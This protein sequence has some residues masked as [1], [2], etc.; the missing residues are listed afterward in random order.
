M[1]IGHIEVST[2][3][4]DTIRNCRDFLATENLAAYQ[5]SAYI[6]ILLLDYLIQIYRC[7]YEYASIKIKVKRMGQE[8]II[9]T[10][11]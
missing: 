7:I 1:H 2:I 11:R 5:L 10:L 8:V 9:N 6:G 4:S 3:I